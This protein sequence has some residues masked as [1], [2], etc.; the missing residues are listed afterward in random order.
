M[1]SSLEHNPAADWSSRFLTHTSPLR[2]VASWGAGEV[3]LEFAAGLHRNC[4]VEGPILPSFYLQCLQGDQIICHGN[5]D[6]CGSEVQRMSTNN[7]TTTTQA[8]SRFSGQS[9]MYGLP[10]YRAAW[11]SIKTISQNSSRVLLIYSALINRCSCVNDAHESS[12]ELISAISYVACSF[13]AF[14]NSVSCLLS[15]LLLVPW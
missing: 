2:A 9:R 6:T 14:V 5:Q 11:W 3:E 10:V 12:P 8:Q 13:T 4:S 1:E 15:F 7:Y